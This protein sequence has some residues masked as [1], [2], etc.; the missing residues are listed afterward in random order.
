MPTEILPEQ[1]G[2]GGDN[3]CSNLNDVSSDQPNTDDKD[4]QA[5]N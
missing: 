2:Y 4:N 5:H 3:H 1:N